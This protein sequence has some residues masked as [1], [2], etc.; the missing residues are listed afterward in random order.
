ML[1]PERQRSVAVGGNAAWGRDS[2]T[3]VLTNGLK[4]SGTA[5]ILWCCFCG[6][7]GYF[8]VYGRANLPVCVFYIS[9]VP[10]EVQRLAVNFQPPLVLGSPGEKYSK[11]LA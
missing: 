1:G 4:A 9:L 3:P 6:W 2:Y 5:F 8:E 7:Q 11:M 10:K